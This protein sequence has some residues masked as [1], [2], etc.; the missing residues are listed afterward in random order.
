MCGAVKQPSDHVHQNEEI[1][2][3]REPLSCHK[4]V[5]QL[6]N[7]MHATAQNCNI[8]EPVT[9]VAV[10]NRDIIGAI[11]KGLEVKK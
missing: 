7:P 4:T 3:G 9:Q 5:A 6:L 8:G 10:Q 1:W 11:T 2:D